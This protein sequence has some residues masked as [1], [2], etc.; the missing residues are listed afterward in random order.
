MLEDDISFF[1][2]FLFFLLSS[3]FFLLLPTWKKDLRAKINLQ[4]QRKNKR[5]QN[6]CRRVN[7]EQANAIKHQHRIANVRQIPLRLQA[8]H[9]IDCKHRCGPNEESPVYPRIDG[10]FGKEVGGADDAPEDRGRVK[11]ARLRRLPIHRLD[12]ARERRN[13]HGAND[14]SHDRE[15][16][17]GSQQSAP[18][19]PDKHFRLGDA[20]IKAK[21]VVNH[22][23]E[24]LQK[25]LSAIGQGGENSNGISLEHCSCHE[26]RQNVQGQHL[27]R[28]A[29]HD[30][31][32]KHEA[33]C[34]EDHGEKSPPR[35]VKAAA[36]DGSQGES[37]ACPEES[38][39]PPMWHT[40]M[41]RH[42]FEVGI[43]V[44]VSSAV[45][46]EIAKARP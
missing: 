40:S 38:H 34:D 14:S 13:A 1:L 41:L 15:V 22:Q 10:V 6:A 42:Q 21:L 27:V 24:T 4:N 37:D 43:V 9:N 46:K 19:L 29:E 18:N 3:F 26:L 39:V 31:A 25:D 7:G 8:L 30:A 35:K 17:K 11:V 28:Y 45:S 12:G 16:D 33:E 44:L 23:V 32:R 5:S 20:H 36:I 2:I